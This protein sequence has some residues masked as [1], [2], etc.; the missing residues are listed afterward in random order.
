M[1]W[2]SVLAYASSNNLDIDVE[3]INNV[4]AKILFLYKNGPSD[5]YTKEATPVMTGL[6]RSIVLLKRKA[7]EPNTPI[8]TFTD[9]KG[10]MTTLLVEIHQFGKGSA[11][12]P[13]KH[14]VE[15]AKKAVQDLGI[16]TK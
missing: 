14:L 7:Q 3:E 6:A 8:S 15:G 9:I 2:F 4:A 16:D 11:Y 10:K 5:N 12:T 1:P 13:V